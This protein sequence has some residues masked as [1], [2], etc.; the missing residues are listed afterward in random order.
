MDRKVAVCIMRRDTFRRV[1]AAQYLLP[2][3]ISP[4]AADLISQLLQV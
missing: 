3:T 4:N 2:N 1:L